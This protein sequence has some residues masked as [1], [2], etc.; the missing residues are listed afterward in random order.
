VL[1]Y[2]FLFFIIDSIESVVLRKQ[3]GKRKLILRARKRPREGGC[4][5]GFRSRIVLGLKPSWP[6]F[7]LLVVSASAGCFISIKMFVYNNALPT[8]HSI[9]SELR[10]L[11]PQVKE[12]KV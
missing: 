10:T 6:A 8:A 3:P 2:A 4:D 5:S 1:P 12:L 11:S 9:I 7:Y